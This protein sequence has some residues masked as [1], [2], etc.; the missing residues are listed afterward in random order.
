[1]TVGMVSVSA[2]GTLVCRVDF[3]MRKIFSWSCRGQMMLFVGANMSSSHN[4]IGE[5]LFLQY[6]CLILVSSH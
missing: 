4:G 6:S 5:F 1:V 2:A 3:L